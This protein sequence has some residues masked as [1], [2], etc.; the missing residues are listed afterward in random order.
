MLPLAVGLTAAA[1]T[2]VT[3]G[4]EYKD[5]EVTWYGHEVHFQ[6]P[7][8]PV[9]RPFIKLRDYDIDDEHVKQVAGTAM[10][11]VG[12]AMLVPGPTDLAVGAAGFYYGGPVGAVGAIALYNITAAGLVVVGYM[13]V[14]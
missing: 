2:P 5:G 9:M 4:F 13:L 1:I 12:A 7:F 10:M 6:D 3:L 11:T 14:S 8:D